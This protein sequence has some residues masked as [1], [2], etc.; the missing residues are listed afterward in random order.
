[1]VI[2]HN[3]TLHSLIIKYL[4]LFNSN[5]SKTLFRRGV[6]GALAP[7]NQIKKKKK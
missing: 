3:F 5:L 2:F 6:S 1:M 4:N 7:F